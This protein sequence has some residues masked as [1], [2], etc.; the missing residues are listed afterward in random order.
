MIAKCLVKITIVIHVIVNIDD[1]YSW[2]DIVV[3]VN[4]SM[5]LAGI[6]PIILDIQLNYILY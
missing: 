5:L 4:Y 2:T 3:S 1:E 6:P